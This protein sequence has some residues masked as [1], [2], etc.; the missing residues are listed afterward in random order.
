[1]PQSEIEPSSV[2]ATLVGKSRSLSAGERIESFAHVLEL[3][4]GISWLRANSQLRPC[5]AAPLR[6]RARQHRAV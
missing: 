3:R 1:V 6:L 4:P 2:Y 5:R